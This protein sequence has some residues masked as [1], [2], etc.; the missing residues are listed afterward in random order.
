MNYGYS[1]YNV[2]HA[3]HFQGIAC[4]AIGTS[5]YV[6]S[7]SDGSGGTWGVP[8]GTWREWQWDTCTPWLTCYV[9]VNSNVNFSWDQHVHSYCG[10]YY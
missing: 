8:E 4:A 1:Y 9:D 6:V 3:Q 10:G 7:A 5:T 2:S